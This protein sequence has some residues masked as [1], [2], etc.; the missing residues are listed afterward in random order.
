P[1]PTPTPTPTPGSTATPTPTPTPTATATATPTPTP[2]PTATASSAG[3]AYLGY[4]GSTSTMDSISGIDVKNN[5]V[6]AGFFVDGSFSNERKV[7]QIN[8][9]NGSSSDFTVFSTF[10]GL[11]PL[12]TGISVS[13]AGEIWSTLS[14]FDGD[15]FNLYRHNSSGTR[16]NRYAVSTSSTVLSDVAVDG[17]LVYMGCPS[18]HQ[19]VI[20][21]DANNP[22]ATQLLFTGAT[23]IN[24]AGVGLD[25]SGNLY[26]SDVISG[27]VIKF[28]KSDGSRMLEFDGKGANGTGQTYSAIGD[29]AVDPRNGDIY[30]LA[31]AGGATKIF[32]YTSA[33]NFVHSFTTG[34]L[35]DPDKIAINSNGHIYVTDASKKGI[36]A[37]DAGN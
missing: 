21:Y 13:S 18:P 24:P 12:I 22:S 10:S 15:G 6:T 3:N 29:V 37:F 16:V 35:V 14:A 26:V 19:S 28:S 1:T 25:S 20:R 4:V 32:R 17:N 9:S 34:D 2:T 30:V 7:R 23:A 27:K 5:V 8:L 33:G 31:V 36:L 11:S